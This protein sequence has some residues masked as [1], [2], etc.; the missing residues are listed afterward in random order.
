MVF[1]LVLECTPDGLCWRTGELRDIMRAN[2]MTGHTNPE[3]I[4]S[5]QDPK[6]SFVNTE[7]MNLFPKCS[8]ISHDINL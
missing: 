8:N 3:K 4:L 6:V 5:V 2:I 7:I 1:S